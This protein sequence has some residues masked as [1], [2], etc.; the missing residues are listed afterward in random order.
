MLQFDNVYIGF[1][2][3]RESDSL[4]K[5]LSFKLPEGEILAIVGESGSGKSLSVLSMNGLVP[6]AR[7]Q[8]GSITLRLND[9]VEHD[10]KALQTAERRELLRKHMGYIFQEPMSALN[11]LMSCGKQVEE[12]L[13]H[14][15][16]PE[17]RKKQVISWFEKVKLP[18]PVRIYQ[19]YPHELSG[20]QRQRVMIA[21]ALIHRPDLIIA[22]EPTTALDASVQQE[23]ISLLHHLVKEQGASMVFISHDLHVV[24]QIA[25]QV[26]V[27]YNGQTMEYGPASS[28]FSA[29]KSAYT[30]AL[31]KVKP[32]ISAKGYYLP[33]LR[34]LTDSQDGVLRSKSFQAVPWQHVPEGKEDILC[35]DQ[36]S[37]A[38]KT[39]MGRVKIIHDLR[40]NLKEGSALGIIGE[41]GSGKST[42]VK[43]VIRLLDAEGTLNF[44]GKSIKDWGKEYPKQVQMIFQDPYAS[45]NP[46]QRVGESI[47]EPL[48]VHRRSTGREDAKLRVDELLQ[49]C[50]LK[51]EDAQKYP[52]QF[53]GGQRQRICIARALAL[54]PEVLL[55]DESV[56]A[57]DV[58]VQAQILNLLKELQ[59]KKNL[60][61]L[62]I[63][64][65]LN[66]AAW[67]C[68]EIAVLYK[69]V[70]V[71]AGSVAEVIQSP[72][73][74][75]TKKL[76]A[77][78]GMHS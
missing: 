76:L 11:P 7:I 52:H 41:S 74:E 25:D 24:K 45:L 29:P 17:Q 64:H 5:G 2:T 10:L 26:L 36:L 39:D 71:E 12:R 18:D 77:A 28:V 58:S 72:K 1:G 23:V 9:G 15:E 57:L 68:D 37:V 55:C 34:D 43:A 56:S 19:A 66:V 40:L 13:L 30:M 21:M 44:K 63:T 51:P 31:L 3:D 16:D 62:F 6:G 70:L 35:L 32:G 59:L 50:G 61:I 46:N 49:L 69:G 33:T 22:D 53:S 47:A 78:A 14:L 27:L 8:D 54:E 75:Y 4:V 65:D 60:S 73:S 20:G 67:F 42:L 38:Y 48:L